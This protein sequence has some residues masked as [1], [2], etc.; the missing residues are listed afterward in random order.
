LNITTGLVVDIGHMES[1]VIPIVAGCCVFDKISV[2][3]V[4]G[5]HIS[6]FLANILM[7][8][9]VTNEPLNRI[10]HHRLVEQ[11]KKSVCYV[12]LDYLAELEKHE[13]NSSLRKTYEIAVNTPMGY[14]EMFIGNPRIRAPEILF[15]PALGGH[16]SLKGLHHIIA[17]VIESFEDR[18]VQDQLS[19]NI[20]L[21]GATTCLEGLQ[22]RIEKEVNEILSLTLKLRGKS[23]VH[24]FKEL[25]GFTASYGAGSAVGAGAGFKEL[26]TSK[27]VYDEEK[28]ITALP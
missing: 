5:N 22:A 15:Q 3:D 16:S 1:R 25:R 19:R 11:I 8:E 14:E 21:S 28:V 17:E 18:D 27:E 7:T 4:G 6:K 9:M 2:L 23:T 24:Y 13:K 10:S 26:Y 12:P 20:I